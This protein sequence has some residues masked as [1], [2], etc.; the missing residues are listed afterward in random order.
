M[1]LKRMCSTI[2]PAAWQ[3]EGRKVF[4][5]DYICPAHD[6]KEAITASAATRSTARR[7]DSAPHARSKT[8]P[9]TAKPLK[10]VMISPR[11]ISFS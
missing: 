8:G 11:R 6:I 10:S 5:E 4:K 7:A 9:V 1:T 3:K 2:D